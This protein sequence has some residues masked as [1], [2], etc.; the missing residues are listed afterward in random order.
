VDPDEAKKHRPFQRFEMERPNELWQMD[1]KG[2]F[3]LDDRGT[4]HPLTILDDHSRFLLGLRACSNETRLTV[5]KHLVS[6]FRQYGLPDRMLMDNGSPWGD[7]GQAYTT[8]TVWLIRLG[9]AVSHGHPYHPQTQGKDERLHRTLQEELLNQQAH[10]SLE[11]WQQAF[12]PWREM[13]N[14]ERPHEA[15][16]LEVPVSR[17]VPSQRA[18]PETL[19]PVIYDPGATV[20][21]V[22]SAGRTSFHNRAIRVG[23]AFCGQLV[24]I[25]STDEDGCYT[26]HFCQEEVRKIDFR[27]RNDEAYV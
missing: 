15:L 3:T 10:A 7:S 5:Q 21:K 16:R 12:D 22:D 24:A 17:Y 18:F 13:Y 25:R 4:C 8:L 23:K 14:Y 6:V 19:P 20:R 26:V 11:E 2:Y 9:I 27:E 1:F